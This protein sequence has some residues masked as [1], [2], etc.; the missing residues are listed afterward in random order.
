MWGFNSATHWGTH[1]LAQVLLPK[2]TKHI[3][4]ATERTRGS[5]GLQPVQMDRVPGVPTS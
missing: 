3:T 2:N 5:P 4:G 1:F